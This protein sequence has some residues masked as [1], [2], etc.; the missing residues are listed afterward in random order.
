[1]YIT[2]YSKNNYRTGQCAF[3]IPCYLLSILSSVS[4]ILPPDGSDRLSLGVTTFLSFTVF[5]LVVVENVPE[6]SDD[7]PLFS[8]YRYVIVQHCKW[9]YMRNLLLSFTVK[10]TFALKLLGVEILLLSY[11]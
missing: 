6:E 7:T 9:S 4:Y 3:Q 10:C 1:M 11:S 2:F 5:G 8:E